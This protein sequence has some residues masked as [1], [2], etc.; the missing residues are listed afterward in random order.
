M[1]MEKEDGRP[2]QET[3][4]GRGWPLLAGERAHYEIARGNLQEADRL[5]ATMEAQT[6][7]C[8][9]IPEQVWDSSDIP[10][11]KLFNGRPTGS[12]MPLVWAHAEYL[13]LLRSLHD[14]KVWGTPPQPIERYQLKRN[15]CPFQIWT[16][17]QPRSKVSG[18]KDLRIDCKRSTTVLW[19]KD[20]WKTTVRAHTTDSGLGVHYAFLP[21]ADCK[22]GDHIA[23]RMHGSKDRRNKIQDVRIV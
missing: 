6:S 4:K 17:E 21:L 19:T 7:E 14:K 20:K 3:G 15:T 9:L 1:D 2:F 11:R 23:F 22:V 10:E 5:R 8:G 13:N 16:A 12:G 18:G